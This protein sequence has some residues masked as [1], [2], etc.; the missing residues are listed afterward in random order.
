MQIYGLFKLVTVAPTPNTSRPSFFDMTGRA[1]WDA[2]AQASKQYEGNLPDAEKHY[3][4]I[5]RSLGWT[6]GKSAS[7][8]TEPQQNEMQGSGLGGLGVSVSTMAPPSSEE[9]E[10]TSKLHALVVDDKFEELTAFLD[11][12][13]QVDINARD[14][15][16]YTPLHLASDRGHLAITKLLLQ[17]GADKDWKDPDEFTPVELANF[18]GHDAIVALLQPKSSPS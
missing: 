4:D 8:S 1:K 18:A 2:W 10:D 6:E 13:P 3:L 7:G 15:Y 14:N 11:A 5:A 12:N 17:K 9:Q 16:G